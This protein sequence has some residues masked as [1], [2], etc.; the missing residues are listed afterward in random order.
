MFTQYILEY[1][2]KPMRKMREKNVL[3]LGKGIFFMPFFKELA[4]FFI[5]LLQNISTYKCIH[6]SIDISVYQHKDNTVLNLYI[7]Q[8]L[9]SKGRTS[10][11]KSHLNIITLKFYINNSL[12]LMKYLL[13]L[14]S[15]KDLVSTH[16]V[17]S[18][19]AI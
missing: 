2:T 9:S 15:N 4:F 11:K 13:S 1:I 6:F 14:Q 19:P 5:F 3:V 18:F 7:C 10:L 12:F 16:K 17:S 8:Y